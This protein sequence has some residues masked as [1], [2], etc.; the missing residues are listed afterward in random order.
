MMSNPKLRAGDQTAC[1]QS[2]L[3]LIMA[4][5]AKDGSQN[6]ILLINN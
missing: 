4:A 5:N 2:C 1:I 6:A 3:I